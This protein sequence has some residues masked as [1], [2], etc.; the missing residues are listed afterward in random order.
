MRHNMRNDL[1]KMRGW[2]EMMCE[3]SDPERRAEQFETVAR[4]LDRWETITEKMEQIQQVLE[5]MQGQWVTKEAGPLVETAV[6]PVREANPEAAITTDLLDEESVQVPA[7]LLEAVRELTENAVAATTNPS[8]EVGLASP[9]D[10]WV[11][12]GVRD[13]G[14]GLLEMETSVLETGEETPLSHGQGLGL[15]M[16]QM[17]VTQAGGE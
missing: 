14:P 16:V 10:G 13:D 2:T 7:T 3:E 12:V 9:D 8:V 1:I 15:W 17:I 5:F 6:T 11:E 4:V